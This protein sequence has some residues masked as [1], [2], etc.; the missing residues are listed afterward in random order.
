MA[1]IRKNRKERR[2]QPVPTQFCNNDRENEGE[3]ALIKGF[4]N[5]ER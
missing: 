4:E 1:E 2:E 5:A 3:S